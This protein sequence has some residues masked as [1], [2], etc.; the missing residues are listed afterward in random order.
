MVRSIVWIWLLFLILGVQSAIAESGAGNLS[1][2]LD[3]LGS[4]AG[5][6]SALLPPEKAFSFSALLESPT[7]VRVRWQ[8]AKGYYLYKDKIHFELEGPPSIALGVPEFPKGE[9]HEDPEFGSVEIFRGDLEFSVPLIKPLS[10]NESLKWVAQFQGCADRGVCYPPMTEEVVL[11]FSEEIVRVQEDEPHAQAGDQRSNF[12][13][14]VASGPE[15]FIE[16]SGLSEE[17]GVALNLR[18]G[19]A[20]MVLLSFLGMGLLLSLTPC[21]FPMMPILSGIIVGQGDGLTP[22]RG[23]LLSLTYVLASSLAYMVFG[24]F[25]GLFGHNLQVFF[26][27]P[28]VVALFSGIFVL[29]ALSMLGVVNVEMPRSLKDR[30]GTFSRGILGGTFPGVALMGMLSALIVGPCVAPP[31]AGALIYIGETGDAMLGG[32]ALFMLGL[33]M[34][35]PL[36]LFGASA[37]RILP[38]AGVW[39]QGVKAFFGVGLFANA[40]WLLS[41]VIPG[42]ASL[43]LWSVLLIVCSVYLGVLDSDPLGNGWKRF[44]RGLGLVVLGYGSLLMVGASMG[45]QDP[46]YP[47]RDEVS[48]AEGVTPLS[49]TRPDAAFRRVRTL[50]ELKAAL[51]QARREGRPSLVDFYADWCVACK[52]M[53]RYTFRDPRVIKALLAWRLLRI[54][55]TENT[56]EDRLLMKNYHLIGPPAVIFHDAEGHEIRNRRVIGY[57]GPE[58]FLNALRPDAEP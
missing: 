40:I 35:V 44:K 1:D 45:H 23:F 33:G 51:D 39:M 14:C 52:E 7:S 47:L 17:C 32:A 55:V 19:Q 49:E 50:V 30:M 10:P 6:S 3:R 21:V 42:S 37:G 57:L 31:L 12:G 24:V 25:A 54:D 36:L 4:R 8:I 18:Q 41:R 22:L 27:E 2:F 58:D 9:L 34:G 15:G 38:K 5:G 46:F 48:R 43:I 26:Q 56:K 28:W 11:E 13:E 29:L 53:E 16:T 20:L